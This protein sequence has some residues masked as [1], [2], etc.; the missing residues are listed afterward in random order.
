MKDEAEVV[1]QSPQHMVVVTFI[2]GEDCHSL[3]GLGTLFVGTADQE[4]DDGDSVDG[5]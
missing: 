5:S 2:C 3:D 1:L 4:I